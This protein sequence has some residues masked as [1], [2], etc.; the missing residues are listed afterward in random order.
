MTASYPSDFVWGAATSAHQAEGIFEGGENGDWYTFEHQ[1]GSIFNDDNADVSVDFWHRYDEDFAL[2]E[3]MGLDS[4]RISI[5]WEKVEP[6]PGVF[7]RAALSHYRDILRS[8]HTHHLT[9]LVALHHFTHPRWF[10]TQG[11]WPDPR[12]AAWFV[13]YVE[14]VEA[15]L[16]DLCHDWITFN[17]PNVQVHLGYWKGTY[18]PNER[19]LFRSVKAGLTLLQ[20]HQGAAK[21]LRKK[22]HRVGLVQSLQLYSGPGSRWLEWIA[23]WAWLDQAM[24]HTPIDWLGVN[25]YGHFHIGGTQCPGRVA[26]NG[27]CL[28]PAGLATII[29]KTAARYPGARLMVG[30]NGLADREDRLRPE[31]L[32]ESLQALDTVANKVHGYYHWSL[33]D[34]FEWLHGYRY[35]FG[36]VAVGPDGTR[37]PR[38]SADIYREEIVRRRRESTR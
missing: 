14:A 10:H 11:G 3:R 21:Y 30:E 17:E 28:D 38:K 7:N 2:A 12:A 13:R 35:H 31:I 37:E 18:P 33:T 34:N 6:Q 16:G 19:S 25:Y 5:A 15:A 4:V 22:G 9:P 24:A 1:P 36:L 27:W 26:D 20:A 8:M 32:R 23:N 29:N